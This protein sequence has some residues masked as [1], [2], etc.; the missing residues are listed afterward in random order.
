MKFDFPI[1]IVD[2]DFRVDNISG[3]GMRALA[4]AIEAQGGSVVAVTQARD[5]LGLAQQS[6]RASAFIVSV[7]EPENG[8]IELD[9]AKAQTIEDLRAMVHSIRARNL[10]IPIFLYGRTHTSRDLPTDVLREM[11]GFM[12]MFEDTNEFMA[13]RVLREAKLYVDGLFTPF[14]KALVNYAQ[15]SSYSWHTPGHSGGV[16]YLKSPVGQL[17]HQFYGENMLRSDVCNSVEELGQPLTHTGPLFD[18]EQNAARIFK[19]DHCFFVTN[20]TSTSNKV[21][22]HASV[23][24]GDIVVVDRNCHKS[25]LHAI[26]MTGAIPVFLSPTRNYH[27]I[28]GPIPKSEFLMETIQRKIDAHPLI[29]DKTRKPK[30][31][32]LTQCTY[33]GIMYN[34]HAIKGMLDGKID[35]LHFDEAWQP[36]AYFHPFYKNYYAIDGDYGR[37]KESLVFSTQSTHK[38]LASLS[39]ASQIL[40]QDATNRP[41][42]RYRFNEAYLMHASTSPQY[43]IIA[44]CD[45]AA[46]MMDEPGGTALTEESLIEAMDFR[47]A[48]RKAE[49]EYA[50]QQTWW[51]SVWGPEHLPKKGAGDPAKWQVKA[52]DDWHGFGDIEP[53]MNMLDPIKTTVMMPGLNMDG[54]FD[55]TGIPAAIVTKYLADYGIII[56][57]VGLYSFFVIFNI[58]ITKGRW[59]SLL[60]ELQQF[61]DIYDNNRPIWRLFPEFGKQYP[62]YE[63]M[64]VRDLCQAIHETYQKHNIAKTI[65]DMYLSK[66]TPAMTPADAWGRV[67]HRQVK[68]VNVRD[69]TTAHVTGVL[70]TPYPP[71]IPLLIPGEYF[72]QEVIDYLNFTRD[73]NAKFPGFEQSA[74]GLIKQEVDGKMEYFIDCVET[75]LN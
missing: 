6:A 14:F 26:I 3:S 13:R 72:T 41:L 75:D 27:G 68:R 56:D 38:L 5:F 59:S 52:G 9:E 12:N 16:A 37:T 42:D 19:A 11:H 2:Q 65:H 1:I 33:D 4:E 46:A 24:P 63:T 71:G 53:N 49:A 48:M 45:S 61:K 28:I 7:D 30:I 62:Q 47:H 74:H 25:N 39:Q 34:A 35:T 67:A 22:W 58:G 70:L 32:T 54:S 23:A 60:I 40:A 64:G 69:L 29:E 51:F 57:K 50:A 8:E 66:I 55:E 44:S 18:S 73:F 36:H 43:S 21:V 31:F 15:N 10:D 20:G 17:F